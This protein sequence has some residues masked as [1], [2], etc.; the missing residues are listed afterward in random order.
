[1]YRQCYYLPNTHWKLNG[2]FL[3]LLI[4]FRLYRYL[5][6]SF[7]KSFHLCIL[8]SFFPSSF[9]PSSSLCFR[10][11]L[12][13]TCCSCKTTMKNI[14]HDMYLSVQC[15][16]LSSAY[17]RKWHNVPLTFLWQ[18]CCWTVAGPLPLLAE[19][20]ICSL[21]S[22]MSFKGLTFLFIYTYIGDGGHFEIFAQRQAQPTYT[23]CVFPQSLTGIPWTR[24]W[25]LPS[26][27]FQSHYSL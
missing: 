25:T 9:L 23:F 16:R 7:H 19:K 24:Q 20:K 3:H 12:F 13:K 22:T 11:I 2:R 14:R 5:L 6:L 15:L 4:R 17:V 10:Q 1:M 26:S 18:G 8:I 21:Q 27:F